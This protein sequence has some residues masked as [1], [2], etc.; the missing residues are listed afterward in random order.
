M[1]P[2]QIALLAAI[3]LVVAVLLATAA[4]IALSATF[5]DEVPEALRKEQRTR[6]VALS[7]FTGLQVR[8]PWEVTVERGDAWAVELSYPAALEDRTL[9]QVENDQLVIDWHTRGFLA[10]FDDGRDGLRMKARVTMPSLETL[11]VSGAASVTFSGFDGT[12][13]AVMASGATNLRGLSSR[14]RDLELGLS[15]A[16]QLDLRDVV[17]TNAHVNLSGV[18]SI[19]LRLDGGTLSGSAS[20]AASIEYSGTVSEERIARSGAVGI[21]HTN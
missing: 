3:G 5:A 11:G 12:T 18:G 7:G 8:G 19:K 14:Y 2:S 10:R 17:A 21:R 15:G 16:G 20:G 4:W 9:A 1:R 6:S 13:L